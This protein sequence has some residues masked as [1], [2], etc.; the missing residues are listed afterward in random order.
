MSLVKE[1]ISLKK[2]N[3]FGIDVKGTYYQTFNTSLD[4]E[5]IFSNKLFIENYIIIGSGS[6]LL[7]VN[8]F[9]GLILQSTN[10]SIEIVGENEF[11]VN[12]KVGSGLVWDKFVEWSVNQGYWGV[13]NLSHIPGTIG[14]ST[15]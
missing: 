13:E 5:V 9:N 14:A 15:P 8:D 10:E 7:F 11:E 4:L 12:V 6:N 3:T 1:N 2:Y